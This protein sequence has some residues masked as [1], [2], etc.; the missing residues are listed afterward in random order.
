MQSKRNQFECARQSPTGKEH[1]KSCKATTPAASL[2]G[3]YLS[4][5]SSMLFKILFVL[6]KENLLLFHQ[7][8]LQV[9][10]ARAGNECP[11]VAV[12]TEI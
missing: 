12:F 5:R 8:R 7:G 1:L 10:N 2:D 4:E 11:L 3:T 6:S 9:S